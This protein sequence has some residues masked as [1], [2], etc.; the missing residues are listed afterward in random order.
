MLCAFVCIFERILIYSSAGIKMQFRYLYA[1]QIC[2]G[3]L[4][5]V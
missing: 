5:N 2:V 4:I 1:A 3:I